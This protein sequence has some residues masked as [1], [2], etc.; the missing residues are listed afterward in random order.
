MSQSLGQLQAQHAE[1]SHMR[2]GTLQ[3]VR[4]FLRHVCFFRPYRVIVVLGEFALR[5]NVNELSTSLRAMV[6]TG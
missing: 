2:I 3:P 5:N 6:Q 1:S 4:M